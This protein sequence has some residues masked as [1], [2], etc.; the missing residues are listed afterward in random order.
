MANIFRD[1]KMVSTKEIGC[2]KEAALALVWDIKSIEVSELKADAVTVHMGADRKGTYDVKGHFAGLPWQNTFAFELN[3][4]GFHSQELNPPTDGP[5]ISGGF[6]VEE[7]GPQSCKLIHY[8]DYRLPWKLVPLKPL[9]VLYLK[10][11]MWKE[12]RTME[13]MIFKRATKQVAIS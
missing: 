7:L 9:I 6:I 12:L 8:E 10:W 3:D 1:V 4:K 13:S 5:N 11:S 2:P